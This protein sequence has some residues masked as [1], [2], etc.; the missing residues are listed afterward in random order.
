MLRLARAHLTGSLS[1]LHLIFRSTWLTEP[2]SRD[3]V[4]SG[5]LCI[6]LTDIL[7]ITRDAWP[8]LVVIAGST[9]SSNNSWPG[10]S[11]CSGNN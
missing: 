2:V 3:D 11:L 6:G 7:Y 1:V 4:P 5:N 9:N 8:P 10:L